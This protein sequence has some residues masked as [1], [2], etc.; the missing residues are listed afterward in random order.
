M[1]SFRVFIAIIAIIQYDVFAK[2]FPVPQSDFNPRDYVCFRT[3]SPLTID[4]RLDET[5]W[6]KARWTKEFVDIQGSIKSK[7][8]YRTRVKMLWDDRFF[9]IAAQ[10]EEPHVWA[11]LKKRDSVIFYD[12]DFEV[13]IDPDGDTHR[14]CELEMNALNTVWDLFLDKPYR[15]GNCAL[16]YWDIGGLQTG[17]HIDGTINDPGDRDSGWSVEIAVPWDVLKEYAAKETPPR[18]GDQW[19]V[20][21]SRVEWQTEI[22][23]SSYEKKSDPLAGKFLPE[24]NWVWSPQGLID[25]HYPEMWGYVQFSTK[26][27]GEKQKFMLDRS[28]NAKWALRQVYY[29]QRNLKG[30]GFTS[31]VEKLGLSELRVRGYHWPV[32]IE[33]TK[34]LFDAAIES[35]DGKEVW[36][37]FQDGR[38]WREK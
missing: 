7:P 31:D 19:R 4:G 30:D 36:H 9:Y 11:T 18:D 26:A 38:I 6:K 5:E 23:G 24:D 34:R 33:S 12:N 29:A 14:Y 15:D 28:E 21:F 3:V 25:M 37:I 16:F 1:T 35:I 13:F 32:H 8:R 27:V 17:V 2:D 22:K 20:N 10:M